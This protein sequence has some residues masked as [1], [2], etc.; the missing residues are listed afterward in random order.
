MCHDLFL[1][2]SEFFQFALR[3]LF[4]FVSL[5]EQCQLIL[6]FCVR[7]LLHDFFWSHGCFFW[8]DIQFAFLMWSVHVDFEVKRIIRQV[9]VLI[10]AHNECWHEFG[11]TCRG[12]VSAFFNGFA[13]CV[14]LC[15]WFAH[16]WSK[17]GSLMWNFDNHETVL[18]FDE[19]FKFFQQFLF[20]CEAE[21]FVSRHVWHQN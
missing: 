14:W 13:I 10:V 6:V 9:L 20:F 4:F 11:Q 8:C 2:I 16:E 21:L 17:L 19:L 3:R 15:C 7:E 12:F 1:I 5:R 18:W